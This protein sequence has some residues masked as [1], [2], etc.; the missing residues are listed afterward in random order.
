MF[1]TG[2]EIAQLQAADLE[3]DPVKFSLDDIGKEIL[4]VEASNGSLTLKVKL[5]REVGI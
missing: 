5:D 4:N 1:I 3:K 2:F